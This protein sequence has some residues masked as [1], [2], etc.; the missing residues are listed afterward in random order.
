[1]KQAT[2]YGKRDIRIEEVDIPE[3]GPGEAL[4][5]VKAVGICG[6]DVHY[7]LEGRIGYQVIE[8]PMPVGHEFMAVVKKAGPG[9]EGPPE[10]TRVAVEPG[11]NCGECDNCRHGRPNLCPNVIFYGTPPIDGC[12]KEYVTH[13]GNLLFALPDK[14][15]DAAGALLEPLGIALYAV[16]RTG[17]ELGDEALVL[18]AGPIGLLT[19]ACA[20]AAGASRII[21]TEILPYRMEFAKSYIADEV[22]E[23]REGVGEA[24]MR[25]TGGRGAGVVLNCAS[26]RET[27]AQ[28]IMAA[29]IGG[30]VGI[31]GIP[32]EDEVAIPVHYARRKELTLQNVRRSR[33]T[34][35]RGIE[36]IE[37]GLV[38]LDPLATHFF[39]LEET[40]EAM[41]LV[42]GYR[43]GVI[44]AVVAV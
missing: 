13:P 1:M 14:I 36:L 6:S 34:L 27:F 11:I 24:V 17:V 42:A 5:K 26:A 4:L 29:A 38:D 7:Y 18:G 40:A 21:M 10:G 3:P 37:K 41:D 28:S 9:Y 33:F 25:L 12:L 16:W 43:D 44:K 19:A 8:S 20:K 15:S 35:P 30:R 2:L 22:L 32:E 31:V 23:G 39:S